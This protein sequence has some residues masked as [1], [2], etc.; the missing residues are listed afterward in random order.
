MSNGKFGYDNVK[1]KEE[2]DQLME[3]H[4]GQDGFFKLIEPAISSAETVDAHLAKASAKVIDD[5]ET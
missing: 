1:L 4:A 5:V 2:L 3:G